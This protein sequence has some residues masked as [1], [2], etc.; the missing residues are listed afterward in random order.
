LLKQEPI[1]ACRSVLDRLKERHLGV[2]KLAAEVSKVEGLRIDAASLTEILK[3]NPVA[4]AYLLAA[5]KMD[6]DYK[7]NLLPTDFA[8][9]TEISRCFGSCSHFESDCLELPSYKSVDLPPFLKDALIK[10]VKKEQD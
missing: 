10:I 9:W 4:A 2:E 6:D 7:K 5:A 1:W 8:D 3:K